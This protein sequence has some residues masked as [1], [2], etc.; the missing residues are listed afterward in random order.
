MWL[1]VGCGGPG[2]DCS[3]AA[4]LPQDA[5]RRG[6]IGTG[7]R[8]ER[9]RTYN[10]AQKRVTDHR[11][12]LSRYD[13]DAMLRGELLDDFLDALDSAAREQAVKDVSI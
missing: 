2:A 1:V 10:F 11:V 6:Q 8:S 5:A 3:P 13:M 9:V 7:D 4:G 12:A